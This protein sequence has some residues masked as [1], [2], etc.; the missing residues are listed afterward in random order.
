MGGL[1]RRVTYIKAMMIRSNKD[2]PV[3]FVDAG[4]LFSDD[5]SSVGRLP[6][7]VLTKNKWVLKSY[8]KFAHDAANI[9]YRELPYL[10]DMLKKDVYQHRTTEFPFLKKM[11]SGNIHPVSD[12]YV[13]PETH[14]IK[15]ITLKRGNPG[16]KVRVAIVGFT[17]RMQYASDGKGDHVAGYQIEDPFEAAKRIL[18]D[19]RKKADYV[20]VLAYMQQPMAERLAMDNSEIDAVICARQISSKNDALHVNKAMLA[21]SYNE[22]RY[23]GELRVFMNP[24]GTIGKQSQRYV[25][26]DDYI[27]DDPVAM[28]VLMEAR[29]EI[30][31]SGSVPQ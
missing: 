16:S 22:T 8:T 4:N 27:P 9:T 28:N 29:T 18:P 15:E 19:I 17:E 23:L 21:F 25:G 24:D 30:A 1:T 10:S 14:V 26:L 11:V 12:E 5:G 7:D 13:A 2:V 6:N 3:I 20:I 31:N